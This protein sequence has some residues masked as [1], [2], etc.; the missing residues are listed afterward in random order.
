[1]NLTHD[2]YFSK[3]AMAYYMSTSQFK[4]FE[5]CEARALA[6]LR[7]DYQQEKEAFKEGHYFEACIT[8]GEEMYFTKRT[9]FSS[10][11]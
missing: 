1:M 6:E 7:G 9:S 3:E 4:A 8:G 5:Q 2:N 10:R 11:V